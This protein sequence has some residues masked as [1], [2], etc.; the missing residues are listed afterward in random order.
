MRQLRQSHPSVIR[1][2]G[3]R[4]P[5]A[6]FAL[7]YSAIDNVSLMPLIAAIGPVD[8]MKKPD[9]TKPPIFKVDAEF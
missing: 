9:F 6:S 7:R 1:T 3:Y 5:L 8:E 2:L 4:L